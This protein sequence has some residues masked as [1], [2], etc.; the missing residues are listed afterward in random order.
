MSKEMNITRLE[1]YYELLAISNE[2]KI[3]TAADFAKMVNTSD[4]NIYYDVKDSGIKN[5]A[6]E[7]TVKIYV[8]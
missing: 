6:R 5:G 1:K 7:K 3:Y 4:N 8:F 2:T